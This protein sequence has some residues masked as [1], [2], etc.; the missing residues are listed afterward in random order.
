MQLSRA[1]NGSAV[2]FTM[3]LSRPDL[4]RYRFRSN[5]RQRIIAPI[6]GLRSVGEQPE[7]SWFSSDN[8]EH[9]P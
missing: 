4:F 1:P 7:R 9:W 3:T 2:D 8:A 6:P 5:E